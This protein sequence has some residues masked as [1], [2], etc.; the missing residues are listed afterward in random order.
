MPTI[1]IIVLAALFIGACGNTHTENRSAPVSDTSQITALSV[2]NAGSGEVASEALLPPAPGK[3]GSWT[4]P[5][6]SNLFSALEVTGI[7]VALSETDKNMCQTLP[8]R[9]QYDNKGT[10]GYFANIFIIDDSIGSTKPATLICSGPEM[11]AIWPFTVG[12]GPS[13]I[14]ISCPTWA[15]KIIQGT[16]RVFTSNPSQTERVSRVSQVRG[17]YGSGNDGLWDYWF[18]NWNLSTYAVPVIYAL[19]E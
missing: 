12:P 13:G 10:W 15:P 14:S 18:M 4:N 1:R 17:N 2:E 3:Y 16:G 19:C 6:H 9:Y 5:I 11:G 7:E 8:V